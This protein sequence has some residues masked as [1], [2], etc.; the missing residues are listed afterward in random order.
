MDSP[1][2]GPRPDDALAV[3]RHRVQH[4][5]ECAVGTGALTLDDFADRATT[6]WRAGTAAE[7]A[8]V[9]DGLPAVPQSS[10]DGGARIRRRFSVFGNLRRRGR[11]HARSGAYGS[12]FG[13]VVLDLRR[14]VVVER[15]LDLRLWSVYGDTVVVVP[16]GVEIDVRSV[17]PLGHETIEIADRP[18]TPASPR[19]R[20]RAATLF[21]DV[22]VVNQR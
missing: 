22:E 12:V 2:P 11:F 17:A 16:E 14:A 7:L 21:G 1:V 6:L 20:I 13:H 5:L 10:A 9:T 19:V 18:R 3:D 8:R 4:Q 15:E